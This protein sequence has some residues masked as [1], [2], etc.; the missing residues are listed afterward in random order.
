LAFPLLLSP[1]MT[2]FDVYWEKF[3]GIRSRGSFVKG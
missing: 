1:A 3:F 2:S